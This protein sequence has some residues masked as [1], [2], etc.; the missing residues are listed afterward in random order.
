MSFSVPAIALTLGIGFFCIFSYHLFRKL[1]LII[2]RRTGRGVHRR[3]EWIESSAF[4]L[5][6]MAAEGRGIGPWEGREDDVPRLVEYAHLFNLTAQSL[7]GR[8]S[9]VES[10][11]IV[12]DQ[13]RDGE[14][15]IAVRGG[16]GDGVEIELGTVMG[17]KGNVRVEEGGVE[18]DRA[19]LL[20]D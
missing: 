5:Q 19:R 4:Q 11:E 1:T 16:D 7:K 18:D 14:E 20:D 2:Q 13:G 3:L 10:Y 6:R 12:T 17:T 15:E 8:W 9:R